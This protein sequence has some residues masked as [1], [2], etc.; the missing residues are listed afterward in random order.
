MWGTVSLR[1]IANFVMQGNSLNLFSR[2]RLN[3]LNIH[4]A[5]YGNCLFPIEM[6]KDHEAGTE[7]SLW[8]FCPLRHV[9]VVAKLE[10]FFYECER[11]TL[12]QLIDPERYLLFFIHCNIQI[13][14]FCKQN[15]FKLFQTEWFLI[16]NN[17]T[18][19]GNKG[20]K[21]T[22]GTSYSK[23]ACMMGKVIVFPGEK[24]E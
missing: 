21:T 12:W 23:S 3:R 22:W 15:L 14:S 17:H 6:V 16:S 2:K 4:S 1:Y 20:Q 11:I 24:R 8:D 13:A 9:A 10:F 7:K 18:V 5:H 19:V